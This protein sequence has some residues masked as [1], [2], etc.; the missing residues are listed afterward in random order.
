[1]PDVDDVHDGYF[2]TTAKGVPKDSDSS[3]R[4]TKDAE[5]AFERIMQNKEELLELRGAAAVHLQPLGARRGLGQPERL[6]DL[7]PPGRQVRRC[8]S[9]SRSVAACGCR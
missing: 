5:S 1:M 7:Q 4:D 2:A 3:A 9:A 6:H 8:A